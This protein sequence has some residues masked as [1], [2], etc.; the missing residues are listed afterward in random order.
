[1]GG[2]KLISNTVNDNFGFEHLS[3]R[4]L[5]RAKY[6]LLLEFECLKSG[7]WVGLHSGNL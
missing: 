6:F 3:L 5:G 4:Y 1:M 2:G 7:A